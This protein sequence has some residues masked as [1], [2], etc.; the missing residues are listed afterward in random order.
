M[1]QPQFSPSSI[2]ILVANVKG[3][4]IPSSQLIIMDLLPDAMGYRC[5]I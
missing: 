5:D 3:A 2:L 4:T 1:D